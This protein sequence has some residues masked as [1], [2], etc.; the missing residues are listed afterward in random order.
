MRTSDSWSQ[1]ER[2]GA[3]PWLASRSRERSERSAKVGEIEEAAGVERELAGLSKYLM[4]FGFWANLRCF[5]G[6]STTEVSA[7]VPA[8][9]LISTVFLER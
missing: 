7:A 3:P 8:N 9:P 6:L 5:N 4:V 2:W 1:E